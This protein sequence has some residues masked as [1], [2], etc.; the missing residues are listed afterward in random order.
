M[1]IDKIRDVSIML[2]EDEE[3]L[4]E[5]TVEYLQMFFTRVYSAACGKMAYEIYNEKRPNIIL[6]DINMPNLDGLSLISKIRQKDK[7]TKIIIMSAHSDQEK[8]LHAVKLHLE[9]YLIKPIKSD[10][11]KKVLFD[12]VEQIRVTTRRIYFGSN[13][14]WD[15]ETCTFWEN[16]AE[17]QLRKKETMLLKLLCS[18]QSHNFSSEDIFYY[19]HPSANENEFS[20]DAVTSLVKRIRSKL[21]KN[22]IKTVYGSGYKIVPI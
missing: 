22:I 4:R 2:A 6:T 14:Y 11:L 21:P 5:S 8:L 16:N 1:K 7:E 15:S 20:N 13:I 17:I 9:T 12:T 3:E 19:L 18:K 10:I